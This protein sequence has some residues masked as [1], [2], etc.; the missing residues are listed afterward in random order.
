MHRKHKIFEIRVLDLILKEYETVS[1]FEMI[2]D[3][4]CLILDKGE[5]RYSILNQVNQAPSIGYLA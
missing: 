2:L 3:T 4:G 5:K 1:F